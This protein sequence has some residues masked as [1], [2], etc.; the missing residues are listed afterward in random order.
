MMIVV[1]VSFLACHTS[2]V[3]IIESSICV[4]RAQEQLR[5]PTCCT[6]LCAFLSS[7]LLL[8]LAT[9]RRDFGRSHPSLAT[10]LGAGRAEIMQLDV[11]AVH[12][13]F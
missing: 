4:R 10:L 9:S 12:M 1:Y 5:C 3:A 11:L 13:D 7:P 8:L 2:Y 6:L